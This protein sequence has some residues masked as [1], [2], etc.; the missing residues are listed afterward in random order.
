MAVAAAEVAATEIQ[1]R[2]FNA[3]LDVYDQATVDAL[4]EN[5]RL[6]EAVQAKMDAMLDRAFVVEDGRRVFKSADGS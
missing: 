2:Q 6:R 5:Q 1:I 4:M 3:K